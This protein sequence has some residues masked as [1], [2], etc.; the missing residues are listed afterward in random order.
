MSVDFAVFDPV[1]APRDGK[2]FR[3]WWD[4]QVDWDVDVPYPELSILVP[5]LRQWYDAMSAQFAD[6]IRS[7]EENEIAIDYSFTSHVIYCSMPSKRANDAWAMAQKLAVD[8]SIGIYDV[9]SDDGRDNKCIRF[10]DGP[11]P[12]PPSWLSR[13]FGK[14]KG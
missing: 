1:V 11:L 7:D 13:I 9:M 8:F 14:T 2:A 10:P 4:E 5:A 3:A 12:N 6:M